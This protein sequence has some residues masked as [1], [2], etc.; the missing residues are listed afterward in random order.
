MTKKYQKK[1]C[2]IGSFLLA[3]SV[4][5]GTFVAQAK[6]NTTLFVAASLAPVIQ[7]LAATFSEK[8]GRT[9]RISAAA[10][11]VLARQIASGAPADIIVLANPA[12]MQWLEDRNLIDNKSRRDL[13]GNRLALL[14]HANTSLPNNM[15]PALN[16]ALKSGRIAMADPDHVP[17]GIYGKAAL[18]ALGLWSEVSPALARSASAPAAVALLSRGEVSAAISYQTDAQLSDK[19]SVH[20]VF[21]Q[22]LYPKIRYQIAT[23]TNSTNQTAGLLMKY[24]GDQERLP[25]FV[26]AGFSPPVS[27]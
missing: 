1:L 13:I 4:I 21:P 20:T 16:A 26:A 17:A 6:D 5:A 14:R 15:V 12:W 22:N 23:I 7:K 24:L 8:T 27:P 18:T 3:I 2:Q 19:V 9:I 10:S 11:S 25:V